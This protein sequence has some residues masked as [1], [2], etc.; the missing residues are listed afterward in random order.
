MANLPVSLEVLVGISSDWEKDGRGRS[1]SAVES[2]EKDSR[3]AWHV[4]ETH[5]ERL[6]GSLLTH[7]GEREGSGTSSGRVRVSETEAIDGRSENV[8]CLI[9]KKS[10]EVTERK[11]YTLNEGDG[12]QE[13]DRGE[14]SS[15]FVRSDCKK[16]GKVLTRRHCE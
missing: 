6:G 9:E 2:I 1:Q 8:S 16:L 7:E 14:I 15:S 3:V 12:K 13:V 10:L 4:A 11:T 5:A